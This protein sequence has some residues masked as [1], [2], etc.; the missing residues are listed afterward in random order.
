VIGD[1]H[2]PYGAICGVG[3]LAPFQLVGTGASAAA[4]RPMAAVRRGTL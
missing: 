3:M 4:Q 2:D 1:P